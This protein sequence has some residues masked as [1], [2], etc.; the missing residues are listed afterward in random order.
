MANVQAN[1]P[2][3]WGLNWEEREPCLDVFL[4]QLGYN[5]DTKY[6]LLFQ[7]IPVPK[8]FL[9][10]LL[11]LDPSYPRASSRGVFLLQASVHVDNFLALEAGSKLGELFNHDPNIA[12]SL[13]VAEKDVF[14]V[15]RRLDMNR[16]EYQ[17]SREAKIAFQFP[18]F[19][20]CILEICVRSVLESEWDNEGLRMNWSPKVPESKVE[21]ICREQTRQTLAAVE[22]DSKDGKPAI[23]RGV[24][25]CIL[26]EV[27]NHLHA[28]LEYRE[29]DCRIGPDSLVL[30]MLCTLGFP[31]L[32]VERVVD[33]AT[34]ATGMN[35]DVL[36]NVPNATEAVENDSGH[37][38]NVTYNIM[39]VGGPQ[40]LAIEF[41]C[42]LET[43]AG[44]LR[45]KSQDQNVNSVEFAWQAWKDAF[46][47]R[48]Q[49][50]TEWRTTRLFSTDERFRKKAM[51]WNLRDLTTEMNGQVRRCSSFAHVWPPHVLEIGFKVP[52]DLRYEEWRRQ[53]ARAVRLDRAVHSVGRISE[54]Q[55]RLRDNPG[56]E[57]LPRPVGEKPRLLL[58]EAEQALS[59]GV[60]KEAFDKF[61]QCFNKWAHH[62]AML[63]AASLVVDSEQAERFTNSLY[64]CWNTRPD[65]FRMFD[66]NQLGRYLDTIYYMASVKYVLRLKG[67]IFFHESAIGE[68][69]DE[70]AIH[71]FET[72]SMFHTDSDWLD[73][74][75]YLGISHLRN[76]RIVGG[77]A[78]KRIATNH[79]VNWAKTR[80]CSDEALSVAYLLEKGEFKGR[81]SG[82]VTSFDPVIESWPNRDSAYLKK[83]IEMLFLN[84]A[85]DPDSVDIP[86]SAEAPDQIE[87]SL[88]SRHE[89]LGT[90]FA[91]RDESVRIAKKSISQTPGL[92]VNVEDAVSL[93]EHIAKKGDTWNALCALNRLGYLHLVG[94]GIPRNFQVAES[95]LQEVSRTLKTCG[96]IMRRIGPAWSKWESR[97]LLRTSCVIL[98]SFTLLATTIRKIF[99]WPFSPWS[100]QCR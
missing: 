72:H 55:S 100:V 83:T 77:I 86:H 73:C 67:I 13:R 15:Q 96:S 53:V 30:M 59:S 14:L 48:L 56:D 57:Y 35:G 7:K 66:L 74:S 9:S 2:R 10:P 82:R 42:D 5:A 64:E 45:M 22:A 32:K 28:F 93:Y 26:W 6:S 58:E 50:Q 4:Y 3:E 94:E 11:W 24:S 75:F 39:A 76:F 34:S 33:N 44:N 79:F 62:E 46:M 65:L 68:M 23:N 89:P 80:P 36:V 97:M 84:L 49:A 1:P 41:R 71:A 78:T 40:D 92:A 18:R 61:L 21:F 43:G 91:F 51:F 38:G 70:R 95:I 99:I 87:A 31:A 47:G 19:I 37:R 69:V 63:K 85:E 88:D 54:N 8:T 60:K 17:V 20:G 52:G 90:K 25:L 16:F 29:L 98:R 27:Q 12:E 81:D